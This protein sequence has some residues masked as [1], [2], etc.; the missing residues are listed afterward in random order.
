MGRSHGGTTRSGPI[1]CPSTDRDQGLLRGPALSTGDAGNQ[2]V[3]RGACLG[4]SCA[5]PAFP[6]QDLNPPTP[7]GDLVLRQAL[8][9]VA[10]PR[11]WSDRAY[12]RCDNW[13]TMKGREMLAPRSRT[14]VGTLAVISP[15]LDDAVYSTWSWMVKAEHVTV[16]SVFAGIPPENMA[17]SNYDRLTRSSHPAVRMRQR[18]AEDEEVTSSNGWNSIH[19]DFLDAPY[20]EGNPSVDELAEA[21]S[22]AAETTEL[23]LIPSAIGSH[24]DHILCRDAALSALARR[25]SKVR[26]YADLPYATHFG[27]APWV[28][29]EPQPEFLDVQSFY[30]RSLNEVRSW[31]V[32]EPEVHPL[33]PSEEAAKL[34]GLR[35]YR[36]QYDAMEGGPTK[37]L[38]HPRRL[39]FE[40][41]WPVFRA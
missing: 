3:A 1:G 13:R 37:G 18:R 5:Q 35:A 22:I 17:P 16:I 28:D 19:L 32:G 15:H 27:W 36:S 7:F 20:R 4:R 41:S 23:V 2:G 30:H 34:T 33:V 25:E 29:G 11:G 40:A 6:T 26:L 39:P 31:R 8:H 10:G 12:Y 21:I 9:P 38:S 24:V 14:A